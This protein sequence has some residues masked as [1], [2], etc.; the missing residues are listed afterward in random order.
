MT[1]LLQKMGTSF[2]RA[3]GAAFI[4]FATGIFNAPNFDSARSLSI[5]AFLG[6]LAAGLRAVQV[7]LPQISFAGIFEQ[8]YAAWLDSFVRA[9]SA[10]FLVVVTGW[11]AAPDFSTWKSVLIGAV[12]GAGA[13]GFRALQGLLTKGEDP[14]PTSGLTRRPRG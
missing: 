7:L 2:I 10:A 3:F 4:F 13:A 6:S 5:A 14:A 11:L 8:P 1:S 9:G 12:V